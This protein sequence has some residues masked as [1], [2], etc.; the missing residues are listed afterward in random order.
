LWAAMMLARRVETLDSILR[1]R[2]VYAKNLDAVVLRRGLRGGALPRPDSWFR[3]RDGHLDAI[4]EA[5][6]LR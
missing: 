6:R 2:P 4:S 1:G 5:G 3:V